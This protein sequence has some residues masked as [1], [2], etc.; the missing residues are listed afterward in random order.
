M[1]PHVTCLMMSSIDGGL[2]P[3]TWT[4]NPDA[5]RKE[6]SSIYEETHEALRGDAWLV[7]RVTMAEMAK[8]SP[9]PPAVAGDVKRPFHFAR[10]DAPVYAIGVDPGAKLHFKAPDIGGDHVVVL[11]GSGV[12]DSHLAE[13][14]G[15]GVSY[16][17]SDSPTI[18]LRAA[19]Q[20][21]HSELGIERLLLEGGAGINGSFLAEGLVDEIY[22]LVAPA[23]DA[24]GGQAIIAFEGG[25]K[26]KAQ[27]SLQSAEARDHGVVALRYKVQSPG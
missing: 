14:A 18:D 6:W 16:I 10:K 11:L 15:D 25:L 21:L 20:T 7:G 5:G 3:S 22:L 9:H 12:S 8:G 26:G 24:T 4:D 13:L 19:L 1:K 27:L 2:H 23:I 17:V